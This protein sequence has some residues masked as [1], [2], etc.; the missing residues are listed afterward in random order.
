MSS[1]SGGFVGFDSQLTGVSV[2]VVVVHDGVG[3]AE[4]HAERG[5]RILRSGRN[6]S[7]ANDSLSATS[8]TVKRLP[9]FGWY[10]PSHPNLPTGY[11]CQ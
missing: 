9:L 11:K 6:T 5:R 8:S 2:F 7:G 4:D 1:S 3:L 10:D